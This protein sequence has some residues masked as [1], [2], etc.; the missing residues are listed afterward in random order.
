MDELG[1]GGIRSDGVGAGVEFF[2]MN[3]MYLRGA[4]KVAKDGCFAACALGVGT[5]SE[6]SV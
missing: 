2:P 5:R 3:R 1:V 6:A 4:L